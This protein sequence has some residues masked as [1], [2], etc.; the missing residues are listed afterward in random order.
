MSDSDAGLSHERARLH[1][2]AESS[3]EDLRVKVANNRNYGIELDARTGR[4]GVSI[5]RSSDPVG[6]LELAIKG[7]AEAIIGDSYVWP[8]SQ[9]EFVLPPQSRDWSA[10]WRPTGRTLVVDSVRIGFDLLKIVLPALEQ[11]SDSGLLSCIRSL[12]NHANRSSIDIT[13]HEDWISILG[14]VAGCFI[15]SKEQLAGLD[16]K[17][18]DALAGVKDALSWVS[19]ANSAAKWG[20]TV[21]SLH[22]DV[23]SPN[24]T[25]DVSVHGCPPAG[26][27][28][29]LAYTT[30]DGVSVAEPYPRSPC[31]LVPGGSH[32]AWSPDGTRLAYAHDAESAIRVFDMRTRSI[33]S[34]V[35]YGSVTAVFD[36]AWSPSG[37]EI[38]Y[39]ALSDRG[40]DIWVAKTDGTGSRRVL[41]SSGSAGEYQPAW[42]PDGT[43]IAYASDRDGDNDIYVANADGSGAPRNITDG[44][45]TVASPYSRTLSDGNE[46]YP[47]WANDGQIAFASDRASTNGNSDIYRITDQN[48]STWTAVTAD[49]NQDQT[50]PAWSPEG[51]RLAFAYKAPTANTYDIGIAEF[52]FFS[53][54]FRDFAQTGF[55]ETHPSWTPCERRG[56]TCNPSVDQPVSPGQDVVAYELTNPPRLVIENPDGTDRRFFPAA[57]AVSQRPGMHTDGFGFPR[58]TS[59]PIPWSPDGLKILSLESDFS[60]GSWEFWISTLDEQPQRWRL[61]SASG[62]S[63][64]YNVSWRWSPDSQNL[65]YRIISNAGICCEWWVTETSGV[66]RHK[67]ADSVINLSWSPTG[68]YYSYD[69]RIDSN[70]NGI[71]DQSD[72]EELWIARADGSNRRRLSDRP[73][74]WWSIDGNYLVYQASPSD[75]RDEIRIL[76][77]VNGSERSRTLLGRIVTVYYSPDGRLVAYPGTGTGLWIENLDGT[78]AHQLD[79]VLPQWS[80]DS[81]RL[82]YL[83]RTQDTFLVTS[84]SAFDHIDI[85]ISYRHTEGVDG[86]GDISWSPDNRRVS[87]AIYAV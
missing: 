15:P 82:A 29:L 4:H 7:V 74:S 17:I 34:I 19:T 11:A 47:A 65:D 73:G 61:L 84:P 42:S 83:N 24:A 86:L 44:P 69:L 8:L 10:D 40:Y 68:K 18:A 79:G 58:T 53:I 32:P 70:N 41:H 87:Y 26:A 85:R 39:T 55:Q 6:A 1:T 5:S 77:V 12:L 51:N 78:D 52:G 27:E 22:K 64:A 62:Q 36:L 60:S 16:T 2:C 23:R 46:T 49:P 76:N 48:D 21:T 38:A 37:D 28:Q 72:A 33:R 43:Q 66:A 25:I 54:K 45:R 30:D 35:P 75:S 59:D 56:R 71:L 9:S 31:H 50:Q 67:V 13:D 20:L 3:G 80:H 63:E 14:T 81:T 57:D